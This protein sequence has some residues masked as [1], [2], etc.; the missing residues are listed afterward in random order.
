MPLPTPPATVPLR[1]LSSRVGALRLHAWT[2]VPD[3]HA[4]EGDALPVVLVHGY[5]ISSRYMLPTLR[6]LG[7]PAYAPDLPGHGRSETPPRALDVTGY[8]DALVGWMNAVGLAR[9]VL[10]GNSLGCQI[11]A[12]AAARWPDRVAGVVLVGP[13]VEPGTRSAIRQALRLLLDALRERPSI[14]LLELA[15]MLRVGPRRMVAMARATLADRIEQVLPA[16]RAPVLVVR[17]A[18][19]PLVPADWARRVATLAGAPPPLEVPGAPHAVNY[20][21]PEA[22][23]SIVRGFVTGLAAPAPARAARG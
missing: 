23:A 14:L 4:P 20:S 18:R 8:A 7:V 10:V 5:V 6:R 11:V 19:D 3:D 9:A 16:L 21:A 17:G 2:N 22:L 13:T 15:D 1:S 12:R